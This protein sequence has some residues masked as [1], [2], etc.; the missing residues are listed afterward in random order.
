[1]HFTLSRLRVTPRNGRDVFWSRFILLF[2]T[3]S[4]K[5]PSNCW[6]DVFHEYKGAKDGA[7]LYRSL[8]NFLLSSTIFVAY[9][10]REKGTS[11][12]SFSTVSRPATKG[13]PFVAVLSK[14]RSQHQRK[15]CNRPV[16]TSKKGEPCPLGHGTKGETC[17][18]LLATGN[19]RRYCYENTG[20]EAATAMH[21]LLASRSLFAF[22]SKFLWENFWPCPAGTI[23]A[24]CNTN[25]WVES[26]CL[27][28]IIII[29]TDCWKFEGY[30]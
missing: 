18:L 13:T 5:E 11:H 4:L 25:C 2:L 19:G 12:T 20:K 28:I 8:V 23:F 9:E 14:P 10:A 17:L 21:H 7:L 29:Y 3:T 24:I 16:G 6:Q 30:T 22:H 27:T 15:D 26:A 1:M